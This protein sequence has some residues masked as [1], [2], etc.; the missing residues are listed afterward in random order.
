MQYTNIEANLLLEL[1]VTNGGSIRPILEP[2]QAV[3]ASV[4]TQANSQRGYL[5]TIEIFTLSRCFTE[6]SVYDIVSI[7]TQS[8]SSPWKMVDF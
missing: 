1:L 3:D 7:L 8:V 2:L 5:Y 6:E 4:F